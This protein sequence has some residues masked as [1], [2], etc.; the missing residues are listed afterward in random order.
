M[1]IGKCYIT[2]A[3]GL[4][5]QVHLAVGNGDD[6]EYHVEGDGPWLGLIVLGH[7]EFPAPEAEGAEYGDVLAIDNGAEMGK[8]GEEPLGHTVVDGAWA[9]PLGVVLEQDGDL[10]LIPG[11]RGERR[12]S[13]RNGTLHGIAHLQRIVR[14]E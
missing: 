12:V 14:L 5:N 7:D 13:E 1:G 9:D 11:R 3:A 6:G 4:L 2:C 10:A 8:E